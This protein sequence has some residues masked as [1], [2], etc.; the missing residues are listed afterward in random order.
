MQQK[1]KNGQPEGCLDI[2][3]PVRA[4]ILAILR[5]L[6]ADGRKE[7]LRLLRELQEPSK[8]EGVHGAPPQPR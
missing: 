8:G 4:E 6:D 7:A 1:M 5:R 3:A 2:A